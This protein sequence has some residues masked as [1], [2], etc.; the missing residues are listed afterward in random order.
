MK[1]FYK[2]VD[3]I[4]EAGSGFA[5]QLD[6]RDVMT[7]K[8]LKL[9]APN[10]VLAGYVA[11]EWDAQ[12]D[13]IDPES[14]PLT[15]LLNTKIDKIVT[16]RIALITEVY[17]FL[18][19]D[20]ICY[21]TDHPA[22]LYTRQ[23]AAWNKAHLWFAQEC[24]ESLQTTQAIAALKQSEKA[25]A[26]VQRHLADLDDDRFT[27]LQI[28]TP[29][30]GSVILALA[31]VNKAMSAEDLRQAV[32]VEEDYKSEL[33]NEDHYGEDPH[34]AKKRKSFERDMQ[35]AAQYLETL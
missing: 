9:V 29:L 5:I 1:R 34:W 13:K 14:M 33:Y 27:L 10:Q 26:F 8:K 22:E 15:L 11:K 21:Y 4:E 30:S 12:Q 16:E 7:P 32:F 3:V 6:G 2:S 24:G 23:K 18:D 31:F 19:T 28:I 17:K 35:A 20:L 25:H